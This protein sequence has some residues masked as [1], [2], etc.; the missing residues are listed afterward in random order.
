M[1]KILTQKNRASGW[2]ALFWE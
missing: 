2:D 1:R